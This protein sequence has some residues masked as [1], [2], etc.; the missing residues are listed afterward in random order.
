MTFSTPTGNVK[1]HL[2]SA[3]G[4][5]TLRH[6]ALCL[7]S[8][9]CLGGSVFC[10]LLNNMSL[11]TEEQLKTLRF[12]MITPDGRRIATSEICSDPVKNV[13]RRGR[14]AFV[15][16]AAVKP[17][18]DLYWTQM[19]YCSS[20]DNSDM[21]K[22]WLP[23]DGI[24]DTF[25]GSMDHSRDRP[26]TFVNKIPFL[27]RTLESRVPVSLGGMTIYRRDVP[28]RSKVL[29]QTGLFEGDEI[30]DRLGS[31]SHVL[32]SQ[33]FGT[34]PDGCYEALIRGA[35]DNE[36]SEINDYM[37]R[38]DASSVSRFRKLGVFIPMF[39]G[40]N[41]E[42]VNDYYE[43]IIRGLLELE[44]TRNPTNLNES[45]EHT[46]QQFQENRNS[47]G[48]GSSST[49]AARMGGK[50]RKQRKTR[51]RQRKTKHTRCR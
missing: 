22:T 17:T 13:M 39:P 6:L 8:F 33:S 18:N 36:S 38:Y 1:N 31:P 44:E 5:R 23:C 47:G 30:R 21:P 3:I 34:M 28:P 29:N 43:I 7:L 25:G 16:V 9:F 2:L 37:F 50:R 27:F 40:I 41:S 48:G 14:R 19:F 4:K 49:A 11:V 10:V 35:P 45:L 20:G 51:R 12:F 32:A 15:V 46:Y 24:V 42:E 26:L